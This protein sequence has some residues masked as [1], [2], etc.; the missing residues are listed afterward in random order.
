MVYRSVACIAFIAALISSSCV[1]GQGSNDGADGSAK[2]LVETG[3]GTPG[4][5]GDLFPGVAK[6]SPHGKAVAFLGSVG[7]TISL[8]LWRQGKVTRLTP[9]DVRVT[10]FDWMPDS[11]SLLVAYA[12]FPDLGPFPP[13]R[14]GIWTVDGVFRHQVPMRV[15]AIVDGGLSVRRDGKM[16]VLSGVP[17]GE[18]GVLEDLLL[19]D[20]EP[21]NV[22]GLT[23]TPEFGE[24]APRFL[25]RK[26][27]FFMRNYEIEGD[28][29]AFT[30]DLRTGNEVAITDRDSLF[31][32]GA[33]DE[34]T[35]RVLY[36]LAPPGGLIHGDP[37]FWSTDLGGATPS[38]IGC[39]RLRWPDVAPGGRS[40]IAFTILPQEDA[41]V[42]I[43]MPQG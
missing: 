20:M 40:M 33:I 6:V 13:N 28:Y 19:L 15:Y 17:A 3:P 23:R 37:C 14:L 43:P 24:H 25:G 27:L 16:A 11:K 5:F 8:G 35:G 36:S 30:L 32:D 1:P 7:H 2:T 9:T 18:I 4:G 29:Q 38:K 21:G 41:L 31:V 10:N 42:Q 26:R 34:K 12:R 39:F 22:E